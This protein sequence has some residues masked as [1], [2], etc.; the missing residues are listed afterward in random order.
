MLSQTYQALKRLAEATP[1]LGVGLYCGPL[2]LLALEAFEKLN[3]LGAATNLRTGQ[4]MREVPNA[5]HVS[6]TIEMVNLNQQYS[7][8]VID[9]I[10]MIADKVR[11]D[12]W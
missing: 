6:S 10:Q 11:G 3:A 2:R 9:E 12:H 8:A 7:V 1:T 5:T 4:E